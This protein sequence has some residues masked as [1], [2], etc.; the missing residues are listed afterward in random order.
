MLDVQRF[1]SCPI[2]AETAAAA[3]HAVPPQ[4]TCADSRVLGMP[5]NFDGKPTPWRV[6][7]VWFVSCRGAVDPQLLD[8][9]VR[10]NAADTTTLGNADLRPIMEH[11]PMP[12]TKRSS[13]IPTPQEHQKHSSLRFFHVERASDVS[14]WAVAA[15]WSAW[16]VQPMLR[17][18]RCDELRLRQ[19][20]T[21][22]Q[23]LVR[24]VTCWR[25]SSFDEL[26]MRRYQ[27]SHVCFGKTALAGDQKS[28]RESQALAVW[29]G[30]RSRY[31]GWSYP[32]ALCDSWMI[33]VP[34]VRFF[35]VVS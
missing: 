24:H 35:L 8:T 14:D 11:V 22:L 23:C 4:R 12:R 16:Q 5:A 3:V 20:R 6:R 33:D 17:W 9:A 7:K 30:R 21:F 29:L 27:C 10:A 28:T 18:S 32:G 19:H 31:R 1:E 34:A 15:V 25:N 2:A 13:V 26:S